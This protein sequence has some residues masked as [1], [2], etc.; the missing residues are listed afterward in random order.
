MIHTAIQQREF[1]LPGAG[2]V[3][4]LYGDPALVVEVLWD[5]GE[6]RGTSDDDGSDEIS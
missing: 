2:E 3:H 4:A 5:L 1:E 6:R